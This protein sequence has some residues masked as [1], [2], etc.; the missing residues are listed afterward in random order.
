MSQTVATNSS[1]EH[2]PG[3]IFKD[4][5]DLKTGDWV[6]AGRLCD[7]PA[8]V[9]DSFP[10][11]ADE[12][13]LLV[14]QQIGDPGPQATPMRAG[15]SVQLAL[16]GEV[17]HHRQAQRREAIALQLRQLAELFE[18]GEV[19]LPTYLHDVD[20]TVRCKDVDEVEAAAMAMSAEAHTS[21]GD[22]SVLWPGSGGSNSG[23]VRARW[24]AYVPRETTS[25][26]VKTAAAAAPAPAPA[27]PWFAGQPTSSAFDRDSIGDVAEA[28]EQVP[29][30]VHGYAPG[31]HPAR[32]VT[33][34]H[35]VITLAE[36][37]D[38]QQGGCE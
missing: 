21:Y 25:E 18:C 14:F 26:P 6:T 8:E 2:P 11:A 30:G 1:A 9:V 4:A 10:Y 15:A 37:D 20:V 35:P 33:G 24:H 13:V 27:R 28:V 31:A 22:R 7:K 5:G 32:R 23:E 34:E 3:A 16:P 29:A 17:E 38:E 36:Q 12:A 19:P